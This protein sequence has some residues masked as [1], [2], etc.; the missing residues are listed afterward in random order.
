[1]EIEQSEQ[2]YYQ[3][4]E[5]EGVAP[6]YEVGWKNK[7]AQYA[8]FRQLTRLFEEESSFSVNDLGCGN[9][10]FYRFLMDRATDKMVDYF[11][12]DHMESMVL[13]SQERFPEIKHCFSVI[14]ACDEMETV[15]FT[16]AS[17]IFNLK[18][19]TEERQW[20]NY[21][22]ETIDCMASKSRKGFGFNALSAYSDEEHKRPEL[23][24]SEPAWLWEECVK[25]FGREIALLHDYGQFDFTIIV[26]LV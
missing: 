19:E 9:G 23:F 26:R 7:E 5:K 16:I 13:T 8:R 2:K 6:H 21:M 18:F 11:G 22:L 14:T 1:M 24:Y 15:D 12:Y 4:R 10:E 20:R 3:K 17:G 25:R